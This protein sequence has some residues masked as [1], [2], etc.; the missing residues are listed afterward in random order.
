[1][2]EVLPREITVLRIG[3][4]ISDFFIAIALANMHP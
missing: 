1:M 3:K 2:A 4:M